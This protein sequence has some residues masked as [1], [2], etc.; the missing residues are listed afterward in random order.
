MYLHVEIALMSFK[1]LF[2]YILHFVGNH[3]I[4]VNWIAALQYLFAFAMEY[5]PAALRSRC[6]NREAVYVPYQRLKGLCTTWR[7]FRNRN[8]Q[9]PL[10]QQSNVGDIHSIACQTTM[11]DFRRTSL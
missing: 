5:F 3:F 8:I 7:S 6:F 10:P 11:C 9:Y 1:E 4:V 2:L